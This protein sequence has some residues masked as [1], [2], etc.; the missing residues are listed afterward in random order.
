LWNVKICASWS[1]NPLD[2]GLMVKLVFLNISM[3]MLS[4]AIDEQFIILV[5]NQQYRTSHVI[6]IEN[7]IGVCYYYYQDN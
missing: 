6:L 1:D 7:P 2:S 5:G 4:I 3:K